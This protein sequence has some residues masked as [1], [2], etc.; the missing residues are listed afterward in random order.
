MRQGFSLV[1]LV[2][3]LVIA[4]F[5]LAFTLPRF[6]GTLD[7]LAADAAVRDVTTLLS[8]TRHTAIAQGRRVRARLADDSLRVDTLGNPDWGQYRTWPGPASRGVTMTVSNPV[9]VFG[10]AGI[11]WGASNTTVSMRRGSHVETVVVSRLG[12]IRRR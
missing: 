2:L 6:S 1:E 7:H 5:V 4:G 11:G 10:P 9:V 8:V 12:R 3:V